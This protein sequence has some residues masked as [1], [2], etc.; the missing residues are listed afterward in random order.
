MS[1]LEKM[2]TPEQQ[3]KDLTML[4]CMMLKYFPKENEWHGK[5]VNYLKRQKLTSV[6]RDSND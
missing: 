2:K 3:V 4:I 5:A 6:F 1:E